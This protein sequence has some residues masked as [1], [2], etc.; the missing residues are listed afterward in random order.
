[1]LVQVHLS[2]AMRG[3]TGATGGVSPDDAPAA[4][5][6]C[7]LSPARG[8]F[9]ALSSDFEEEEEEEKSS[10]ESDRAMSF[11]CETPES[12]SP[13]FLY[14]KKRSKREAKI[15]RQRWAAMAL[16]DSSPVRYGSS[17]NRQTSSAVGPG[18][19]SRGLSSLKMSVMSP[20]VDAWSEDLC[21]D[22]WTMV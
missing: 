2:E 8:R 21:S 17:L 6:E 9:W 10:T 22:G 5:P 11:W 3:A 18:S 12:V 7:S 19:R 16:R 1:M 15:K 14:E 13:R 20:T 4:A